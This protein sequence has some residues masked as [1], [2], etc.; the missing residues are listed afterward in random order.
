MFRYTFRTIALT[1]GKI[2]KILCLTTRAVLQRL[3]EFLQT[4]FPRTVSCGEI[5]FMTIAVWK[6]IIFLGGE[7]E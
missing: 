4:I 1:C 3:Q 7:N 5:L 2:L 6:R